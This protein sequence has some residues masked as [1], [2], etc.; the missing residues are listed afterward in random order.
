M[1]VFF[2]NLFLRTFAIFGY[3]I[4][5]IIFVLSSSNYQMEEM[6][7]NL[8]LPLLFLFDILITS[9]TQN[10]H[11]VG[12][13]NQEV[14]HLPNIDDNNDDHNEGPVEQ[15]IDNVDIHQGNIPPAQDNNNNDPQ[16]VE[17][18]ADNYNDK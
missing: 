12:G 17:E 16:E 6:V 13:H 11:N 10:N 7:N 18:L 5:I 1:S 9:Y 3:S 4:K 2:Q 14:A 8:F 15:A